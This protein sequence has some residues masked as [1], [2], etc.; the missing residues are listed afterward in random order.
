MQLKISEKT[1]LIK[2][3]KLPSHILLI[4]YTFKYERNHLFSEYRTFGII[5]Y[6]SSSSS[7]ATIVKLLILWKADMIHLFHCRFN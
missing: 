2:D 1:Y 6:H 3:I 5:E 7:I 4:K